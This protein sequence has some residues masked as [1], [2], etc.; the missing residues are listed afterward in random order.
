MENE[1][2]KSKQFTPVNVKAGYIGVPKDVQNS[3]RKIVTGLINGGMAKFRADGIP[4]TD[5]TNL[6]KQGVLQFANK[7]EKSNNPEYEA[8]VAQTEQLVQQIRAASS[9]EEKK[10]LENE[11]SAM[12]FKLSRMKETVVEYGPGA[13]YKSFSVVEDSVMP[14]MDINSESNTPQ[15][16]AGIIMNGKTIPVT[17]TNVTTPELQQYWEQYSPQLR[18][19]NFN[20][21]WGGFDTEM[22]IPV[23]ML[24][25]EGNPEF[26]NQITYNPSNQT[27]YA[28][29]AVTQPDGTSKIIKVPYS[30]Y[31]DS[32]KAKE[33]SQYVI[34]NLI[35]AF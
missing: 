25:N 16:V 7:G 8:A 13:D 24:D 23:K 22:P 12:T 20:A 29:E 4:E 9:D 30:L 28:K 11:L 34:E 21:K 26:T 6:V 10:R 19:N 35:L 18:I 2:I 3:H 15:I 31:G 17:L 5:L 33:L 32:P 1:F 27:V 14:Q